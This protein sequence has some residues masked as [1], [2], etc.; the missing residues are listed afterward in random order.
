MYIWYVVKSCV[1]S[2][3]SE[4]SKSWSMGIME[5]GDVVW[6]YRTEK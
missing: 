2:G 3:N 4:G 5:Q 6:H 1:Y